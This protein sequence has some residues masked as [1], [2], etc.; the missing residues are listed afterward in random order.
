M[1]RPP[2]GI[3]PAAVDALVALW[4]EAF[5]GHDP[6]V[7]VLD[8]AEVAY[9][10]GLYIVAGTSGEDDISEALSE[11]PGLGRR[12]ADV[13]DISNAVWAAGGDTDM[14]VYRDRA[15]GLFQIARDVVRDNQNLGGAVTRAEVVS[16]E[17][18][19]RRT[20]RVTGAAFPFLIRAQTL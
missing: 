2:A 13:V 15:D 14:K 9:L 19:P 8:G 5:A 17:Y 18:R 10:S 4:K 7:Q 6:P 3:V 12:R 11:R 20:S 16:Y 1:S